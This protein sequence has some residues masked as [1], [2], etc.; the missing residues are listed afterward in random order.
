MSGRRLAAVAVW[1][2]AML[3]SLLWIANRVVVT[4]D[5]SA[6]LPAAET[7]EQALLVTQLRDGVASRLLLVGIEGAPAPALAQASRAMAAAL[8]ADPAFEFVANGD[9]QRMLRERE[10]AWHWRYLL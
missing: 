6:F 10:I 2:A 5:L 8:A 4:T 9:A 3:A 1:A 7:S